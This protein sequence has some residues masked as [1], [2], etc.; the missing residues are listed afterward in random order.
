MKEDQPEQFAEDTGQT[1]AKMN[2]DSMPWYDERGHASTE[3]NGDKVPMTGE[4]RRAY[5]W[6]AIRSGLL[7]LLV[8]AVVFFLFLVF[9]DTIWFR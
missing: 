9:C 1:I 6:A 7:I 8:F 2:V 3:H 4:E 5:I